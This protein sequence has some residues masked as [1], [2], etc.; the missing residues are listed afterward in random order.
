MHRTELQYQQL[1]THK[2]TIY[3]FT[4]RTS[5][6]LNILTAFGHLKFLTIIFIW[7]AQTLSSFE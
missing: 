6:V 5:Y 4:K 2:I 3:L 1:E 7:P